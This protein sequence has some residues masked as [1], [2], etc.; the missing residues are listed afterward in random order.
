MQIDWTAFTPI[1]ALLGGVILGLAAALY[2]HLHGRLLGVSG[3]VGGLTKPQAGDWAWR[4]S[5]VVG[6]L[7]SPLLGGLFFDLHSV[8]IIDAGWGA[9][10]LA[11]LLVGFGASYGSG[12]TSGHG[13]CGLARLSARSLVATIAFM[14]A[15][16]FTV[17]LLRHVF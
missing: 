7:S 4:L 1:P 6:L 10:I 12:C 17:F 11:G 13:I 2:I 8:L 15:G 14:G 9:L 16:F 5:F 3:I